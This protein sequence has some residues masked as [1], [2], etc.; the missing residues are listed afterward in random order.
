VRIGVET[1]RLHLEVPFAIAR[2]TTSDHDICVARIE[3]A[4][5]VGLGEAS[6][7]AYYGDSLNEARRTIEGA[8]DML[9]DEAFAMREVAARL[10][11]RFPASPSGRA[12]VETAL[13][14]L[15]G[16][17]AGVPLY[18]LLGLAG[19]K[20]PRTSFTVGVEDVEV[21]RGR[22]DILRGF[23]ILKVKVGFGAE[24][25]LVQLLSENTHAVLR[26]DANEGWSLDQALRR[27]D[28]WRKYSIEFFEQPLPRSDKQAYRQLRAATDA[29]IFVD[30]GVAT[31][32]DIP[33][34]TG[35]VDG[36]NIKIMKCGGLSEAL[37]MIAT[38]RACGLKVML[39]CM[40][41]SA[42]GIT[43]AAQISGLAD[44]CDLD[45]NLLISNDP[46]QGVRASA[47]EIDL[48]DL[49]GL[50]VRPAGTPPPR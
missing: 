14:D 38:A 18:K 5:M 3:H 21:A 7:S 9:G 36:I 1:Y 6:P 8:A 16:K 17:L 46:F 43:A 11:Q 28:A 49:P 13:Y 48:P 12:A 33:Q 34:W 27:I 20:P 50:G 47:G 35:L 10:K 22:L 30:E 25:R 26:V 19:R 44:F 31:S 41:E 4:G 15:A 39:G 23:P 40:V 2:G 45:G 42:L 24:D 37:D 32:Q 29:T